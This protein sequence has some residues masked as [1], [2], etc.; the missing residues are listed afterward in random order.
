MGKNWKTL[1]PEI[2]R[3]ARICNSEW[4]EG[5]V[6]WSSYLEYFSIAFVDVD[7]IGFAIFVVFYAVHG[8]QKDGRWW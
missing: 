3:R 6:A 5:R 2:F 7:Y 4:D 8:A 1:D